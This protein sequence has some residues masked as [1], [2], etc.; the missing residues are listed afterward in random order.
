MI[1]SGNKQSHHTV[2]LTCVSIP[3]I[4]IKPNK[5]PQKNIKQEIINTN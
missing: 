2:I 4:E 1:I 5:Y 3:G